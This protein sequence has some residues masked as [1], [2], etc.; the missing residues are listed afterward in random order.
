MLSILTDPKYPRAALGIEAARVT[1]VELERSGGAFAI[2]QAATVELPSNLI[3][4]SFFEHNISDPG[5]FR[6]LLEE[7]ATNAGL[8]GQRSWSVSL[9][10]DTARTAILT[11]EAG[12]N[13]KESEEILD[14][15]AEQTFGVPAGELRISRYKIPKDVEGRPRYLATAVKLAVIDEYEKVFES[16]GW[17]AGLI[18]PR[19]VSET[20]WLT[21]GGGSDSL[22]IS[23]QEAGFTALLLRNGE[24]NVVRSVTCTPAEQDDEIYRLL[25]FYHD[26]VAEQGED[27][28]N[29]FMVV[30]GSITPDKIRE[31]SSEALGRPLSVLGPEDVG[32]SMPSAGGLRFDDLAAPAGL[33]KLAY[34]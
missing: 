16:L 22:L 7:A 11:L 19:V 20:N 13:G 28:L 5:Q 4:P 8:M 6:V 2:R 31:I 29:R 24:P 27:R 18:L 26:R 9:P 21:N 23:V 14:W 32:L 1:A 12:G 15:K 34:R 30:G 3:E 10:S 25:M 33:A 17:K